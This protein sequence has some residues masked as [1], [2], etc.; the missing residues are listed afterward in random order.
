MVNLNYEFM[1]S[2]AANRR[3]VC[4]AGLWFLPEPYDSRFRLFVYGWNPSDS[5]AHAKHYAH[6]SN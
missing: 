5:A 2:V 4:G 1:D 3:V 6:L